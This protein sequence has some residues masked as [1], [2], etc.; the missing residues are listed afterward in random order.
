MPKTTC[1]KKRC[2]ISIIQFG[3]NTESDWIHYSFC[4]EYWIGFFFKFWN[5]YRI[6]IF[7]MSTK[8]SCI[9][10]QKKNEHPS[11]VY[12]VLHTFIFKY[13]NFVMPIPANKL[14]R[15]S[16]N[17]IIFSIFVDNFAI[18]FFEIK[19]NNQNVTNFAYVFVTRFYI[20]LKYFSSDCFMDIA[21]FI[22]GN[23]IS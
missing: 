8:S 3:M 11:N 14:W 9:H 7:E 21:T 6:F 5:E 2:P 15:N 16:K 4:N 19:K 12:S 17:P 23:N 10:Y 20:T 1:K 22:V 13:E 18:F